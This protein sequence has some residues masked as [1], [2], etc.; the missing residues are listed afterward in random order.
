MKQ[1]VV[2]QIVIGLISLFVMSCRHTRQIARTPFPA[3]DTARKAVSDSASGEAATAFNRDLVKR[4]QNNRIEFNTFSAR[5]KI[6]FENEKQQQHNIS[7]NIRMQKD[8]AIWISVSAPIIGEVARALIT[9]D[10][11]KAYDRFNKK[12]YLRAIS[13]AKDVL[14]VPF[15]FNTLQDMIVGN[16]V[17]LTDSVYQV[18]K[19]NAIISFSCDST[20]YTSLFN[21][22]ADDY[23]LQQSK[24]TDKKTAGRSCELTY[25]EYKDMSGHRFPTRRRI[26][27]EEKNITRIAMDFNRVDFNQPVSF[28][29]SVP[30]SGYTR[31]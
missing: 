30:G 29:F 25:G 6:D 18:V 10:S 4:I 5:L 9:K 1:S 26:F 16:P 14:N 7:T 28:P 13:D 8:S 22:F 27:I 2:A 19:T 23:L 15:D 20:L 12:L 11:L 17:F 3:A 24:V 31:E 21:V